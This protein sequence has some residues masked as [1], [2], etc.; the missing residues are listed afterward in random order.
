V[1]Q[2]RRLVLWLALTIAGVAFL[3]AA[4][5]VTWRLVPRTGEFL[6]LVTV[7]LSCS[8]LLLMTAVAWCRLPV[9][10]LRAIRDWWRRR[11]EHRHEAGD[12]A[13]P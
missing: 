6:L 3:A 9:A 8:V 11:R 1:S 13:P 5:C 4:L 10:G 7:S 12:S 2:Q